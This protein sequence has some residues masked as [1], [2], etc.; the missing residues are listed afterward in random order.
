MIHPDWRNILRRAWSV[1]LILLAGVLSAI[2][3]ALPFFQN[4]LPVRHGTF[5]ILSALAAMGAF[6]ARL[7]AQKDITK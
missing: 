4:S 6:V 5:G 7:M 1:R 2:E 3:V